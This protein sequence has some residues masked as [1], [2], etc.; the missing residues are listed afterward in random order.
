MV[1][2]LRKPTAYTRLI[3]AV[4]EKWR[5]FV[6]TCKAV[7]E[8]GLVYDRV[9]RHRGTPVDVEAGPVERDPFEPA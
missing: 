5:F 6:P 1:F 9:A 7:S 3:A 2:Y 4:Q 8:T